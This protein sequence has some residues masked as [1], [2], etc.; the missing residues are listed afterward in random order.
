M[1]VVWLGL[2]NV[3]DCGGL[4]SEVIEAADIRLANNLLSVSRPVQGKI[5]QHPGRRAVLWESKEVLRKS[6]GK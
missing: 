3:D 1:A 6:R 4:S 2:L 5:C